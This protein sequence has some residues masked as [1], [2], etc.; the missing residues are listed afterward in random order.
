M[1]LL[2]F[3]IPSTYPIYFSLLLIIFLFLFLR[4]WASIK[5]SFDALSSKD[6]VIIFI[7]MAVGLWLRVGGSSHIDLDPYG[8]RYISDALVIK[9]SFIQGVKASSQLSH[10]VHVPGYPFFISIPLA[11]S[12]DLGVISGY[13][14]LFS[15]LSIGL[16]YLLTHLITQERSASLCAAGMLMAST[17]HVRYSGQEVPI[18]I[19]VFFI[20]LAFFCFA[21]WLKQ[22]KASIWGA[23]LFVFLL[24]FNIK[25]ENLIWLPFFLIVSFWFWPSGKTRRPLYYGLVPILISM[26]F[27]DYFIGNQSRFL[28]IIFKHEHLSRPLF[29]LSN[30]W[31][32]ARSNLFGFTFFIVGYLFMMLINKD[33]RGALMLAWFGGSLL[34]FLW[35]KDPYYAQ[36]C[37]L[38]ALVPVFI[39]GGIVVS[40]VFSL[41]D[42]KVGIRYTTLVFF[43]MILAAGTYLT[44]KL[45]PYSWVELKSDIKVTSD[46]DCIVS[47]VNQT[48]GFALPFIFPKKHWVFE[49]D[50]VAEGLSRCQGKVYYFN[51]VTYGLTEDLEPREAQQWGYFVRTSMKALGVRNGGELL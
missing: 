34:Y 45:K 46:G 2:S 30:I 5:T 13:I 33:R 39:I 48:S 44:T 4:S 14:I 51:P 40:Y 9:G 20:I 25:I 22:K 3:F 24:A 42:F 19:S 32:G 11:V 12:R 10:A 21:L 15:S 31:D 1:S 36:A 17:A 28:N 47:P 16:V 43:L 29:H 26:I 38:Q 49:E 8:W 6:A 35:D 27:F 37:S 50:G 18:T 41:W 7:L 23:T